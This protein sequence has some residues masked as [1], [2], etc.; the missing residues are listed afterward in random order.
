MGDSEHIVSEM[1][2]MSDSEEESLFRMANLRRRTRKKR[3]LKMAPECPCGSLIQEESN[4]TASLLKSLSYLKCLKMVKRR[5][6]KQTPK[7]LFCLLW[8]FCTLLL[9]ECAAPVALA[10]S[11]DCDQVNIGDLVV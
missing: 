4:P 5:T 7:T 2:V 9:L 11:T 3:R 8:T 10:A 1:A 6:F